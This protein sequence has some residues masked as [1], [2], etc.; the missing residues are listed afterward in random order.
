MKRALAVI[1]AVFAACL[2]EISDDHLPAGGAGNVDT[3]ACEGACCPTDPICYPNGDKNAPGAECLASRDNR[4]QDRVQMRTVWTRTLLPAANS[5][6]ITYN[7]LNAA[8]ALSLEQCNMIGNSGYVQMFDWDRSSPTITDHTARVGYAA[9]VP[10]GQVGIEEGLCFLDFMYSDPENGWTDEVHVKPTLARRVENDFDVH[11]EAF[12]TM[13]KDG[14]EGVFF[15]DEDTGAVHGYSPDAYL[16]IFESAT[17]IFVVPAHEAEIVGSFNDPDV[18]NCQGQYLADELDPDAS[19]QAA[20][21]VEPAWGCVDDRCE[22]GNGEVTTRAY[23][24]IEELEQVKVSLLN[25]TLCVAYMGQQKAIDEGWADPDSWGLNCAG[26]PRWQ[27]GER[28]R[29][30]WCSTTNAPATDDCADAWA[31]E[32]TS[33][34]AATNIQ[35]DPCSTDAQ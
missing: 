23:F 29:G 35:D 34:A 2:P 12:R 14:D 15:I 7:F 6:D 5:D 21:Q 10:D 18:M 3:G 4:G 13:Y 32:N 20:S 31:S 17:N 9:Y 30:D 24:L 22:R 25:S 19:C 33:V 28:P 27:A 26:S 1:A 11:D 8:T 16:V